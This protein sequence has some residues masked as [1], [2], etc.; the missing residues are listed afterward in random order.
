MRLFQLFLA[1]ILMFVSKSS[2][3]TEISY[4]GESGRD[5]FAMPFENRKVVESVDVDEKKLQALAVQGIVA[6]SAN[7]RAIV[8]GKIYQVGKEL[9]PGVKITRIQKEGVFVMIGDKETLLSRVTQPTK[10][11]TSQ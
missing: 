10:G 2:W 5:P 4:T 9:L 3:C 7:P 8:N 11:K 6:S 1:A